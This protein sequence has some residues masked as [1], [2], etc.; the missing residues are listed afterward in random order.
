MLSF[1]AT[2][3][4]TTVYNVMD[5]GDPN[6]GLELNLSGTAEDEHLT[7]STEL[8]FLVKWRGWSHL[9]NTWETRA[10]LEESGAGGLKRLDNFM[11]RLEELTEW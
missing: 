9:H 1:I 3:S 8:Q 10:S 4:K 5:Q 11:K 6:S 7:E 2:G